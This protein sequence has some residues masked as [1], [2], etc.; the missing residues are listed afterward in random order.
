MVTASDRIGGTVKQLVSNAS[1]KH[2]LKDQIMS[3]S[4]IF[5]FFIAQG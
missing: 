5:N 4:D 1:L 2:D 3:T